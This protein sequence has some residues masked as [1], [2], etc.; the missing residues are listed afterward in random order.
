M[1]LTR[2]KAFEGAELT[3]KLTEGIINHQL[4]KDFR[5]HEAHIFVFP[6]PSAL[7]K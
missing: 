1:G 2:D 4:S 7:G 3:V 5:G 6:V